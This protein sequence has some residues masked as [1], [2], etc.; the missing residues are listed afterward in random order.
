[1]VLET[2]Y[3][4][5]SSLMENHQLVRPNLKGSNSP[6]I[7]IHG[8]SSTRVNPKR[9]NRHWWPLS[10]ALL[11][12][13]LKKKRK[14]SPQT[15]FLFVKFTDILWTILQITCVLVRPHKRCLR[16]WAS[17]LCSFHATTVELR[18]MP[19]LNQANN[20][21]DP[22]SWLTWEWAAFPWAE[23]LDRRNR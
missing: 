8:L 1:M 23:W 13:S 16:T 20:L 14:K 3:I 11:W 7:S 18:L 19:N 22:S 10:L 9:S 4:T 15:L 5:A 2:K 21:S 6:W 17:V 12:H